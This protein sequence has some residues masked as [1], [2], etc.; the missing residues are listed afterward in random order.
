M[1]AEVDFSCLGHGESALVSK[2]FRCGSRLGKECFCSGGSVYLVAW[3]FAFNALGVCGLCALCGAVA[4]AL[5]A[6]L[7]WLL[8]DVWALPLFRLDW[9][10][11]PHKSF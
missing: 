3:A 5:E 7:P 4:L 8:Q 6:M 1:V 11:L 9:A 2:L 10:P